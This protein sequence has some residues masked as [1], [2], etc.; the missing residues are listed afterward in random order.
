MGRPIAQPTGP[1][2]LRNL[3][4][5]GCV[6][7]PRPR[8]YSAVPGHA[9]RVLVGIA[10]PLLVP[11]SDSSG[12]SLLYL[13]LLSLCAAGILALWI[14]RRAKHAQLGARAVAAAFGRGSP[15]GR[16]LGS[17]ADSSSTK[18]CSELP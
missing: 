17:W 5:T 11:L 7:G 1:L 14:K 6:M 16:R 8:S 2:W 9:E 13:A 18:L 15:T 4:A 12:A 10:R 3:L